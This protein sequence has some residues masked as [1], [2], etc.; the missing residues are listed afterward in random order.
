MPPE[1]RKQQEITPGES[2][3]YERSAKAESVGENAIGWM[4]ESLFLISFLFYICFSDTLILTSEYRDRREMRK[5]LRF[6]N[7]PWLPGCPSF[8]LRTGAKMSKRNTTHALRPD[9]PG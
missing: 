3:K 1:A 2:P 6:G 4:E 7:S 5:E 8:L 9:K